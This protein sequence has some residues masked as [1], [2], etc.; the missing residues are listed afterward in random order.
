MRGRREPWSP[1]PAAATHRLPVKQQLQR[2]NGIRGRLPRA[3]AGPSQQVLPFQ[4]QRD[5]LFLD[6]RGSRPAQ[7]RDGLGDKTHCSPRCPAPN[8]VGL[9]AQPSL[10][11]AGAWGRG[12][13]AR[14][15][16]PPGPPCRGSAGTAHKHCKTRRRVGRHH[17]SASRAPPPPGSAG[18]WASGVPAGLWSCGGAL[19]PGRPA[20]VQSLAASAARPQGMLTAT[21]SVSVS[22]SS[23]AVGAAPAPAVTSALAVRDGGGPR[24]ASTG[25]RGTG[26]RSTRV[27]GGLAYGC[28]SV[29]R[30]A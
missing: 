24:G 4:G 25:S 10:V 28:P 3:R 6:Q 17:Q 12:P 18:A 1:H 30:T 19:G 5:G 27:E 22:F 9:A 11:P 7:V 16:T 8:H 26:G 21:P 2:G 14:N 15:P 13:C 23:L 29:T 20:V